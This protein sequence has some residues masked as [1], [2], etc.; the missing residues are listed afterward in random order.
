[1]RALELLDGLSRKKA[2]T[3]GIVDAWKDFHDNAEAG[4]RNFIA[5]LITQVPVEKDQ[6]DPTGTTYLLSYKETLQR[7]IKAPLTTPAELGIA[8]HSELVKYETSREIEKKTVMTDQ[9]FKTLENLHTHI[10]AVIEGRAETASER[11]ARDQ[12]ITERNHEKERADS[13]EGQA[14]EYLE[15]LSQYYGAEVLRFLKLLQPIEIIIIGLNCEGLSQN[16]IVDELRRRGEGKAKPFVGA[17]VNRFKGFIQ[18]KRTPEALA[19][20][21]AAANAYSEDVA[22]EG[23]TRTTEATTPVQY[24]DEINEHET[25]STRQDAKMERECIIKAYD[26]AGEADKSAFLKTYSWLKAELEKRDRIRKEA[27]KRGNTKT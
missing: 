6:Q 23:T 5:Q 19:Q 7:L 26:K 12:A 9:K 27:D 4:N 14:K 16:K 24:Y 10:N 15:K 11:K 18:G 1:M 13:A 20:S 21:E 2:E 22:T 3:V 17:T 8:E 25:E